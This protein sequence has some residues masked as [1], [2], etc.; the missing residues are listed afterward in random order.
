M[1]WAKAFTAP[2]NDLDGRVEFVGHK[3]T[4]AKG[5]VLALLNTDM[6][7][8]RSSVVPRTAGRSEGTMA[9]AGILK[10]TKRE[11]GV[12]VRWGQGTGTSLGDSRWQATTSVM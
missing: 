2:A 3:A 11:I 9:A 12:A 10:V 5:F 1:K 7:F 6:Y 8:A 4:L